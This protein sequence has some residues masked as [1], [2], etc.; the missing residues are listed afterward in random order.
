MKLV[1]TFLIFFLVG[2]SSIKAQSYTDFIVVDQF[3]YLPNA[4]KVAVIRNP[5]NGFDAD[6]SFSPGT[7]YSLVHAETGSVVFSGAPEVWNSGSTDTSSGDRA[8][9]FDFSSVAETGS[10]YVLDVDNEVR[11]FEFRISPSVYNEV[12]KQAVRTFFYQR[13]GFAKETPF[14]E[15]AWTDG[16]SHLGVLQDTEARLFSDPNN[17]DTERDVSGGWY[18][19]GDY[20][21]YTSWTANYVIEMMYAY[22]ENP[23]VWT[24][25]FNIPESGNGIPDLLDEARWGLDHLLKMQNEDGSVLSVV[26]VAHG[27]PPSSASGSSLY[28]PANT[29]ATLTTAAA[30]ELASAVFTSAGL[31]TYADELEQKAIAAWNWAVDNPDVIFKNN[32][33]EFNSQGLAAGQQEVDDYGRLT[34]KLL[35]ACFLFGLTGDNQYRDFFDDNYD[36]VNMIQWNFAFPFQAANQDMLLYYTSLENASPSVVEHIKTVYSSSMMTGA[37]NYPA[38]VGHKDPYMAHIKDY[39]WGSNSIKCLKGNMFLNMP[40]FEAGTINM[41]EARDIAVKYINYL[42][43]LNPMNFVYLSNMFSHGAEQGV[44]EFYHTWFANG[45]SLW[46]RFGESTYG[47]APGFITGGPNPSYDWDGCCPGGCGSAANNQACLALSIVPP[48]GQPAQKSYKDFNN[49]WPLNSWSVTENSCGYQM[50]YIRLL[51]H[52]ADYTYDCNGD[53]NGE[54]YIDVCGECAGGLTGQEPVVDPADCETNTRFLSQSDGQGFTLWPN[55]VSDNL[56]VSNSFGIEF[57]FRIMNL[58]GIVFKEGMGIGSVNIDVSS[59]DPGVY[60]IVFDTGAGGFSQ[61]VI[62]S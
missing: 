54:A 50:S 39:V 2:A 48:K 32:D 41:D 22:Q 20:N 59:L 25:A 42:H 14:A 44:R 46:D 19:A 11:S 58:E 17:P 16:A 28:G 5:Q 51:A 34:K 56:F 26:G 8:W 15:A 45:S 40:R 36:Q 7:A 13:S 61:K 21:K 60:F 62:V 4:P 37:E 52:F 47:P 18:D 31:V 1:T 23:E 10:Y 27:S 53:L 49:S 38:S 30:F 29:S 6:Q 24:D 57:S 33:A 12:L 55:P 9:W 35:A 43:G 3:G